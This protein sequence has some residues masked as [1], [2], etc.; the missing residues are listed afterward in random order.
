[1]GRILRDMALADNRFKLVG[2]VDINDEDYG[3]YKIYSNIFN[4]ELPVDVI[5]DFSRPAALE[6]NLKFAKERKTGIVI[7]TTGFSKEQLAMIDSY[8]ADIPVFF[9]ANMS[10]GVNL[11]MALSK[12]TAQFFGPDTDIEI[13][14]KHHNRKV[15]APSGTALAIA[16]SINSAFSEPMRYVYGRNPETGK[17]TKGELCFHSVRGGTIVGEH[18]VLFIRNNEIVEIKHIAE[19]R[20]IFAAGSLRAA[21]FLSG[22]P[23][24]MYDMKDVIA[25]AGTG[26]SI[27]KTCGLSVFTVLGYNPPALFDA[28][29][30]AE[31]D[32]DIINSTV[33]AVSAD[34]T[35]YVKN[36]LGESFAFTVSENICAVKLNGIHGSKALAKVYSAANNM[37]AVNTADSYIK[38]WLPAND[39]AE[40]I[41]NLEKAFN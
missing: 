40:A 10:L 26:F 12:E 11:Q 28:L 24:G 30:N 22:K 25:E 13:I 17:R 29:S 23:C 33:F 39:C 36:V 15:D 4:C 2:G 7:A 21:E 9:S 32:A 35:E 8:S 6:N 41:D 14:E 34:N 20:D 5:I 1:M 19:S 37:V 3:D 38:I 31:I 16:K 27:E 18:S